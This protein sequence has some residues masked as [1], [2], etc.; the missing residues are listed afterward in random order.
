MFVCQWNYSVEKEKLMEERREQLLECSLGTNGG[1][2]GICGGISLTQ[3]RWQFVHSS[4]NYQKIVHVKCMAECLQLSSQPFIIVTEFSAMLV[5]SK[6]SKNGS[7]LLLFLLL[8]DHN[9]LLRAVNSSEKHII[10]ILNQV[11]RAIVCLRK[12]TGW[13]WSA[14]V[15][16]G[17]RATEF[18]DGEWEYPGCNAEGFVGASWVWK[19]FWPGSYRLF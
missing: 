19:F 2:L 13:S 7:C 10:K 14:L 12:A 18:P 1:H 8:E 17:K 4:L 3:E 15:T 11:K 6:L 9:Y 16:L 5:T